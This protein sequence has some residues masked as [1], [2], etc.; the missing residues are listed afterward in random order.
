MT[1]SPL[2]ILGSHKPATCLDWRALDLSLGFRHM[3]QSATPVPSRPGDR[4][5][6]GE[7][8]QTLL[9]FE[10]A[11]LASQLSSP[12][13]LVAEDSNQAQ[14]WYELLEYLQP[15]LKL[16][17][18]P[19]WETL[20]Y[21]FFSPHQDILSERLAALA[22]MPSLQQAVIITTTKTLC[23]RLCP[24]SFVDSVSL[25]LKKG[26]RLDSSAFRQRLVQAS[27]QSVA[28]VSEHG[29][30]AFRGSLVDIY[31]MGSEL[32]VRVELFDDEVASLRYFDPETQR[33][34]E[35]VEVIEILPATEYPLTK[36]GRAT[37]SDRWFDVF[38]IET[39]ESPILMDLE[40]G[41]PTG[42]IEYY[43]PLFFERLG[44][45]FD[46]LPN[47]TLVI[48][49]Q[50]LE[51]QIESYWQDIQ[52][53]YESR[54]HDRLRPILPP[55]PVFLPSNEL[56]AE[57]KPR[58]RISLSGDKVAG[59]GS[60]NFADARFLADLQLDSQARV[61]L[62]GLLTFLAEHPQDRV[63]FCAE[64]AGRREALLELLNDANIQAYKASSLQDAI[65]G[66]QA[67]SL[68][69]APF[70]E[71][72]TWNGTQAPLSEYVEDSI[73]KTA[74]G[75]RVHLITENQLLGRRV[76]QARRR[77]AV[78][79]PE[80]FDT[81]VGVRAIA[82][83]RVGQPIVHFDHGVGRYQG[84]ITLEIEQQ[85]N[86]FL[87]IEYADKAKLYVPVSAL[88]LISRYSGAEDSRAPLH[89]L[90][91]EKW[92][93]A[94]R[95]A[96]EK[97]RDTA[98]ELLDV[99]ATRA[100]RT[101]HAYGKPTSEYW[102]FS[103]QFPFEETPDQHAAIQTVLED[104]SANK[105]MDRL[106]CGDVGFGKTEVALR[107]A[108][109]A[110]SQG[111]QVAVLVPTTLLAQQ[112]YETFQNRFA[113]WPY[114]VAVLSRFKTGKE[115]QRLLELLAS[116]GV[117]IV[118]GT[119]KLLQAGTAFNDLGLLIIDEEHR[120]G[121]GQKEKIKSFK[122]NVDILTMTATPIPRTLNMAMSGMRDISII[123]TPPAK[124]ISIKTFVHHRDDALIREAV[125]REILRGGQ[126]YFLHNEVK[127]MEQAQNQ[128]QAL[129]PEAR[130]VMAHGQMS[131]RELEQA[132]TDFYHKRFN[133]LLCST[134]IETG[135]DVPSANTIIIERADKFGLAQLHQLRGRVGRS[136]HQAYAY[137]LTPDKQRLTAD[138]EKRLEAI[139]EAQD[140]GAGFL[141][142]T[143]D[144][145]IRGAGELLG[146][147]QSGHV[148][149]IGFSLF[150]E[151]LE[152][153]VKAIKSGQVINLDQAQGASIDINLQVPALIP[154][155]YLMDV[156][157]RLL[158]YKR[159]ANA[160][161]SARLRE[162]QVE[163][164]DRFGLLPEQVKYLFR[165]NELKLRLEPLGIVKCDAHAAGGRIEFSKTPS[166][167]PFR[168]VQLVQTRPLDYKLDGAQALK[169]TKS[170]PDYD[171]RFQGVEAVLKDLQIA[172]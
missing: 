165:L 21:D 69:V 5:L 134:I 147:E 127:T 120:F 10:V 103:A 145:E 78:S 14:H 158:L 96:A 53:R 168:L 61:P 138:A 87:C 90:G 41:I 73:D 152:R 148:Q 166:I 119:H 113:D 66:E 149:T 144:L 48:H 82:E 109:M 84:L 102:Q 106:V 161:D 39:A 137:L 164:I 91:H 23:Q 3:Y 163:M 94:K 170:M 157:T 4:K 156:H 30:F 110:V 89:K 24:Q 56:F 143:Q 81:E 146:D 64:S 37:F 116:G 54:R 63:I 52:Q 33:S 59:A 58:A 155:S 18:F 135:I 38:G 169:F 35:R 50:T 121:V 47:E 31:P 162:L 171:N 114:R 7:I 68:L 105:P 43:L 25:R 8:N 57:L 99:Y 72:M 108:F 17:N 67:Y 125:L 49:H 46:Y 117:D 6:W 126:V 104:M 131:E 140:L 1:E 29:E 20:P 15:E 167:D 32:P 115:Q 76:A 141:L 65:R 13:L 139:A 150:M 124:R 98:A 142:A 160:K 9:A 45:L 22:S 132:M 123:A 128:L 28:K 111:K 27:Y 122:A 44:T 51:Q 70:A 118:V 34:L 107:A 88:H 12:L 79:R 26:Q 80:G 2:G 151:M 133:L 36:E 130:I 136:H 77:S 95:K 154:E 62:Q 159:I 55:H 42:G 16:V 40:R 74:L 153:A 101:G 112:H 97:I 86:E 172:P 83:L 11:Q 93:I 100:A 71:A 60:Y 75:S 85:A 92:S 129:I 19:D